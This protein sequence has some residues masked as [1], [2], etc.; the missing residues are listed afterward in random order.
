MRYTYVVGTGYFQNLPA[1]D[2]E[3]DG[4]LTPDQRELLKAGIAMGMYL[5]PKVADT[6]LEAPVIEEPTAIEAHLN[7]AGKWEVPG[8]QIVEPATDAQVET[9]PDAT[10]NS[11]ADGAA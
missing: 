10:D 11:P 6:A 9:K 7:D 4:L 5:P 1:A 3:D 2:I 8:A